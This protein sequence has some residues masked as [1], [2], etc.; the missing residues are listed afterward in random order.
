MHRSKYGYI[1]VRYP[2]G[3]LSGMN[4]ENTILGF[5]NYVS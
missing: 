4:A 3:Y 2:V 5:G 1:S